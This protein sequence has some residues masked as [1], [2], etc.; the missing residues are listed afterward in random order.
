MF[1]FHVYI[2]FS[3]V[4]IN[5]ALPSQQEI[6]NMHHQIFSDIDDEDGLDKVLARV[7]NLRG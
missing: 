7:V 3:H 2:V 4:F 1:I 5:I 6:E